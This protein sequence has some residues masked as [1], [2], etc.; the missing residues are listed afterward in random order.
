M[1]ALLANPWFDGRPREA[2]V[3]AAATLDLGFGGFL[4]L[5]HAHAPVFDGLHQVV[6]RSN[7][8]V[9]VVGAGATAGDPG[10]GRPTV[11]EAL[12]SPD[13]VV[14]R[15]AV[16]AATADVELLALLNGQFLLVDPGCTA[17]G[18]DSP[19]Q[20]DA[21]LE[22]L[23]L[24]LFELG[25]TGA[26]PVLA[27][28]AGAD[29]LLDPERTA[30]VLAE[31]PGGGVRAWCDVWAV[32]G[33]QAAGGASADAWW[34]LLGPRTV[35]LT[36]PLVTDGVDVAPLRDAV[37]RDTERAIAP[38]PHVTEEVLRETLAWLDRHGLA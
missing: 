10:R 17:P 19:S 22:A 18:A 12:A 4:P 29:S 2:A 1:K 31:V 15:S 35:G 38:G 5:C 36:L 26:T 34:D 7:L 37:G 30:M 16:A 25:A 8:R 23:C 27:A 9:P 3:Q 32:V 11:G 33:V 13:P 28:P 20:V 24:S 21:A 14:R 6:A